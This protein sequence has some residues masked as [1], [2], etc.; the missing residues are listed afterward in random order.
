MYTVTLIVLG[1]PPSLA[2]VVTM[3]QQDQSQSPGQTTRLV[4]TR[5]GP[6]IVNYNNHDSRSSVRHRLGPR[7]RAWNHGEQSSRT[8][9]RLWNIIMYHHNEGVVEAI[10]AG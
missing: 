8:P 9:E 3:S 4:K 5:L 7:L 6:G 1:M 10:A 2:P